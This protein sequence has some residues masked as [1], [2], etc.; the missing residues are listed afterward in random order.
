MNSLKK[1]ILLFLLML[2][3]FSFVKISENS[4]EK[5]LNLEK[6]NILEILSKQKYECRPSSEFMF[7][8]ETNLVKKARGA[9]TINTKIYVLDRVSGF[10]NLLASENILVPS[11]KGDVFLEYETVETNCG[12]GT[13][14]NGDRLIGTTEKAPY[15]FH[16]LVKFEAIYSSYLKSKNNLLKFKKLK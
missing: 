4:S 1:I 16:E 13:L 14:D 8:V 10:S 12:K 5:K 15:C 9:N 2:T 3:I 6:V 11:Y 7:Y